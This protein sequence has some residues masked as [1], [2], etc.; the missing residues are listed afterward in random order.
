MP[1]FMWL[2]GVQQWH[3]RLQLP[4][5]KQPLIWSHYTGQFWK[6]YHDT[7]WIVPYSNIVCAMRA[8]LA[9]R[10]LLQRSQVLEV[11]RLTVILSLACSPSKA[12]VHGEYGWLVA[13]PCTCWCACFLI[14]GYASC[15]Q[16]ASCS[17]SPC[18]WC[19]Y[20]R[21]GLFGGGAYISLQA[22]SM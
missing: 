2:G 8:Y 7:S 21:L 4:L 13:R 12:R 10:F 16:F 20:R 18:G 11:S 9:L 5:I 1:K 22:V 14:R 15:S 19:A 17:V 3:C 6:L